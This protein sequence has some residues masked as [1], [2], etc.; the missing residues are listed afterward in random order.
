MQK[1]VWIRS[2][3]VEELDAKQEGL[4]KLVLAK[5]ELYY[6]YLHGT[7]P[8]FQYPLSLSRLM[9]LC[10]R[11]SYA[12]STALKYLANTVPFDSN[13]EP[14]I[15]YDRKPARRNRSHRPYRIFLRR[16][17]MTHYLCI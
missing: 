17:S 3:I 8:V 13:A 12:V 14:P 4:L 2:G 1:R 16:S 7:R 5:I 9:K 11:N 10:N 6:R 15:Y